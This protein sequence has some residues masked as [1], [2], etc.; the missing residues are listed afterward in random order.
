MPAFPP[1]TT[2]A[3]AFP[4]KLVINPGTEANIQQSLSMIDTS[5]SGLVSQAAYL[6]AMQNRL[7]HT[8]NN[9]ANAEVN[10]AASESAIRDLDMADEMTHLTKSQVIQQSAMA[11]IA[12][13]NAR[14]LAVLEL[15]RS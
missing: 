12:Q 13:S 11:M 4:K 5:Q 14:P 1:G 15:L 10:V 8:F 7:E 9:V 6:G 3:Q 2:F